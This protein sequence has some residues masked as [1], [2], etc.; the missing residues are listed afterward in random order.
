MIENQYFG[1]LIQLFKFTFIKYKDIQTNPA[2]P[3]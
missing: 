1:I 2:N 3:C